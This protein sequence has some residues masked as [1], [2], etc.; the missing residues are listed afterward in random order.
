[1]KIPTQS[2]NP[3]GL[4]S[5]YHVEK[6]NGEPVDEN[7]EYFVLR[8]DKNG[9]DPKHIAA[10]RKAVITYAEE[11]RPYLPKLANDLI[12]RYNNIKDL[13]KDAKDEFYNQKMLSIDN[14]DFSA[15]SEWREVEKHID[16]V[17]VDTEKILDFLK[18]IDNET[19]NFKCKS[20]IDEI[21]KTLKK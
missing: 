14:R 3:D 17:V 7:A 8:V 20:E 18:Y 11:I 15:A 1:M 6:T 2:E 19:A 10:C 9:S 12:Q 13:I 4:H 5:R 16:E 21:I